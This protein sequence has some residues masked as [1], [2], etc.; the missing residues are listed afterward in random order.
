[1]FT[2]ALQQLR[3]FAFHGVYPEERQIGGEFEVDVTISLNPVHFPVT[4]LGQSI[5]YG[6]VYEWV[7]A[8]MKQ[9][10]PL[11]ETVGAEIA[12]GILRKFSQAESVKVSISKLNPPIIAF[13][14]SVAVECCINR[15]MLQP[16]VK[17]EQV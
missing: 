17:N 3:F 16:D 15:S 6:R 1:M 9:P 11:L 13:E 8:C 5:D 2:I 10:Q 14:G 12:T 7:K 4:E